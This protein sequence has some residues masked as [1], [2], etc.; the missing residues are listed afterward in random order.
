M[1]VI[2][3]VFMRFYIPVNWERK[4]NMM[5]MNKSSSLLFQCPYNYLPFL[6]TY[7]LSMHMYYMGFI[8]NI[9]LLQ[10]HELTILTCKMFFLLYL[11]L[12]M[13]SHIYHYFMSTYI[14]ELWLTLMR[15]LCI[16]VCVAGGGVRASRVICRSTRHQEE[17]TSHLMAFK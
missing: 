7:W 4:E 3:Y 10:F 11:K 13:N 2:N 15:C 8:N 9:L 1:Y 12:S 14:V 6:L 17:T 16:T 5:P